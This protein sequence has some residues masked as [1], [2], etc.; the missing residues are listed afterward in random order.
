MGW[1]MTISMTYTGSVERISILNGTKYAIKKKDDA[2]EAISD[3]QL[4]KENPSTHIE[5][6]SVEIIFSFSKNKIKV[7]KI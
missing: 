7:K 4:G 6:A 2:I 5:N 3:W 1:K